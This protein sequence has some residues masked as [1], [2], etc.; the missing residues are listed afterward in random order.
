MQPKNRFRQTESLQ[1]RKKTIIIPPTVS[2]AL[3]YIS[4]IMGAIH[5]LIFCS[6]L[7][8]GD[9][10][11][12]PAVQTGPFVPEVPSVQIPVAP[13]AESAVASPPSHTGQ[14]RFVNG[15]SMMPRHNHVVLSATESAEL[16]SL[17]TERRDADGNIM[18]NSDGNPIIIPITRGMNVFQGQ[19]LVRFD[20]R[21]LQS[22]LQ[23]NQAQLEVAKAE[24]GKDIERVHAAHSA[25]VA[26]ANYQRVLE[27]NR[28]LAGTVPAAE[29]LHTALAVKQA[30]SFLD[31]Q[32]YN[33]DEIKTREVTVRQSE[34]DRTKSQ[35]ERRQLMTPINGMIA[36]ISAAE[37][38]WLREGQEV[39]EIMQ[40]DTLW[41]R[42]RVNVKEYE[43]RDLDG[44]PAAVHAAFPNG[45]IE[46]FQGKVVFCNPSVES[47][48]AFEVYVEV[49]NRR[50]GN[51]WLLQ[52]GRGNVEVVIQL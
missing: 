20:D 6:L 15:M 19:V 21:E 5:A 23:I 22:I 49:Q 48:D 4:S 50:S 35:I 45:R 40:L 42:I 1:S 46:T 10:T 26:H 2:L 28:R 52:P 8:Q 14:A 13:S 9:G 16:M 3:T 32:T 34:L 39:L 25:Q 18:R 31:L 30:E 51:F 43:I 29:V 47:D 38:E 41:V 12:L 37:G 44:K 24:L 36:K 11:R 27:A 17:A 7:L 33:I